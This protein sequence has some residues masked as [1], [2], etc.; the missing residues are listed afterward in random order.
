LKPG[1]IT[2]DR[3]LFAAVL[4]GYL[5]RAADLLS[6]EDRQ[7]IIDST[8][9]IS[10][11]LGLRFYSDYLSG[12]SYFKVEYPEQNLFR[13]G[14]QFA[15]VRSIESQYSDLVAGSPGAFSS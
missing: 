5:S 4:D 3:K 8:R 12:N 15:L 7:L 14:A 6:S 10:F 11:E 9:L 2:S 1:D 13:A